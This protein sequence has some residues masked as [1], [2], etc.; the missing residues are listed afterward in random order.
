VINEQLVG[1]T[2][3][4]IALFHG[5]FGAGGAGEEIEKARALGAQVH[6]WFSEA[7]IPHDA[8]MDELQKVRDFQAILKGRGLLGTYA[9]A[10]DLRA[11]VRT[12]LEYDVDQLTIAASVIAEE[13]GTP[14]HSRAV[15]RLDYRY[16]T[17]HDIDK[18]GK[19]RT[20]RRGERLV[21]ENI[22]TV[23]AEQVSIR[24][25][26]L[27]QGEAPPLRGS[28][29]PFLIIQPHGEASL[30]LIMHMGVAQQVLA[31]VSW[32]EGDE[33][34]TEQHTVSLM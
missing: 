4:V 7:P 14:P 27:G 33:A 31:T 9:S 16:R 8:D 30:P 10:D 21:V 11:K 26:P 25:R 17:E 20:K 13:S 18:R 24:V 23:A 22:G 34:H 1:G 29:A 5:R 32:R 6:V 28:E 2:D 19:I 15:L 12:A 3:I